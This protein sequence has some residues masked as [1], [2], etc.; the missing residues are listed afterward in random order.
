MSSYTLNL[1]LLNVVMLVL[2]VHCVATK[3]EEIRLRTDQQ[4]NSASSLTFDQA[5]TEIQSQ[6]RM[7]YFSSISLYALLM[8]KTSTLHFVI[9]FVIFHHSGLFTSTTFKNT[10]TCFINSR[11]PNH[12]F[13]SLHFDQD[14]LNRERASSG[15]PD[16]DD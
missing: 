10:N 16:H 8:W 13:V 14:L 9:F 12:F 6:T 2:V 7:A 1:T 5:D 3:A 11:H 4:A 15:L